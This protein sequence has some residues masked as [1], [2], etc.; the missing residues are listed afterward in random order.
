MA[1]I[2]D[3]L[4]LFIYSLSI[5]I[6]SV[7]AILLLSGQVPMELDYRNEQTL[8]ITVIA[9]AVILFLLSIRFFYVSIRTERGHLNA[10]HQ[11]TEFGD[12]QI[13]LETIENMALKAAERTRGVRDVKTRV[14]VVESGL[15]IMIRAIVDG[16]HSIPGLSE[17]MQKSIQK[18][19][20]DITG[21][22]VSSVAVYIANIVQSPAFKSRVE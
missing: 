3:R 16:E 19:I 18:Q 21:I 12:I 6:L 10:V 2:M 17:E 5:G 11:R 1:K 20:E 13:S 14:R 22:P 8:Y 9:V 4:L 15:E 7:L